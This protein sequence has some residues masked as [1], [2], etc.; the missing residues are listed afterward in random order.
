LLL[1]CGY[2]AVAVVVEPVVL[3]VA[4]EDIE[5]GDVAVYVERETTS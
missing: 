5:E 4:V 2:I 1:S 3:L